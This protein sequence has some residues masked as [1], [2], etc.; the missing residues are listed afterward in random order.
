LNSLITFFFTRWAFYINLPFGAVTVI[1]VILFLRLPHISG[2]F[3]EKLKR[4]DYWGTL[5][6]VCSTVALLLPLSWGGNKYEWNSPVIIVL[7]CVGALGFILFVL[8][9]KYVAIEPIAPGQLFKNRMV[10]SCFAVSFFHGMSFFGMVYFV[11][12]FFQI[13]KGATGKS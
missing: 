13:V 2:S 11:P 8:V 9:E 4:I 5:V 6:L 7:L 1:C 10:V 12:L 3:L